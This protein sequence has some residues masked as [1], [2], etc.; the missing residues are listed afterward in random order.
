MVRS[1][2][3]LRQGANPRSVLSAGRSLKTIQ[4]KKERRQSIREEAREAERV[5]R[6]RGEGTLEAGSGAARSGART[7]FNARV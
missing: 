3:R 6:P 1:H 4:G 2:S 7:G 5:K